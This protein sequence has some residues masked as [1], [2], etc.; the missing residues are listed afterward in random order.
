MHTLESLI[1]DERLADAGFFREVDHRHAIPE[2]VFCRRPRLREIGYEVSAIDDMV[3][4]KATTDGRK[5]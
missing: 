1:E 2:P 5:S 4:S 3:R